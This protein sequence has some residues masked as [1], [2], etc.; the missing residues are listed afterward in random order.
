MTMD[1]DRVV[2]IVEIDDRNKS[3]RTTQ[4]S[5]LR[6]NSVGKVE[7]RNSGTEQMSLGD[8]AMGQAFNRIG[9]PVQYGKKLFEERPD[10]VAEQFNHWT[11]KEEREVLLRM[12]TG[13]DGSSF[14]RGFLSDRYSI[15]DNNDV[16]LAMREVVQELPEYE[17]HSFYLDDKRTHLRMTFPGLSSIIGQTLE[18]QPDILRLGIDIDNSEVG[19]SSLR[20]VPMV[21]RLVC[22]N[23]LRA[24]ANDGDVYQQR[25]IHLTSSELF[26]RMNTAIVRAVKSGDELIDVLNKSKY[27]E[28]EKPLDTIQALMKDSKYSKDLTAKVQDNYLMEAM[29][30]V[31]GVV[32]ALTRT[33]RDLP[34]ERKIDLEEFAGEVL[35]N[36]KRIGST[37]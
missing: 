27:W 33:A 20:V 4:L 3:D 16:I 14:I 18:G 9:I 10:L 15:L 5:A 23:G 35:R 21:Y 8:Y 7:Y 2:E 12:R 11:Q 22:T 32:N 13:D 29:P 30:N 36:P 34:V 1:F 25:H 37:V 19:A 26:G 24:W 31:Y 28:V 6:M 17:I